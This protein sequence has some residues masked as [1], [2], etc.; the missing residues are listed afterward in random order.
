MG[1]QLGAA[2][3]L[4]GTAV[5]DGLKIEF[6]GGTKP[7]DGFLN[8]ADRQYDGQRVDY[9]IDLETVGRDAPL[10][11]DTD[12]VSEVYSAHCF[13]HVS[14]LPGLL[15][16]IGRACC[17]GAKVEIHVPHHLN[18]D[19]MCPSHKHVIS[20]NTVKGWRNL[21]LCGKRIHLQS[22]KLLPSL[23]FPEAKQLHPGW[24]DEQ[25][26]RFVPGTAFETRFVLYVRSAM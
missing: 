20:E 5:R 16:E 23:L 2:E 1:P 11:F 21:D 3:V 9:L 15:W 8:V 7:R 13:E 17:T 26:M 6:G 10:P 18:P 14:N 12:S 22:V 25:I 24:T 19:A 4:G